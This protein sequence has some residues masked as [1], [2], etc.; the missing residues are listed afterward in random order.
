[1]RPAATDVAGEAW[2]T[3]GDMRRRVR[4]EM[5]TTT[6]AAG[7]TTSTAEMSAASTPRMPA[8]AGMT[9]STTAS[10]RSRSCS[11]C[12]AQG[13]AY[14]RRAGC[15]LGHVEILLQTDE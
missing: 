4:R 14:G 10:V 5:G 3:T 8:A 9:T 12:H 2:R 15:Y 13:N 11:E 7:M 6:S 1:M